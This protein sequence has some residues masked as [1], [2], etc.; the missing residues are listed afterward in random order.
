M[1][2]RTLGPARRIGTLEEVS[3]AVISI[4]GND[5]ISGASLAVD[6]GLSALELIARI[7]EFLRNAWNAYKIC[8][9]ANGNLCDIRNVGFV[10]SPN[11]ED[12][13]HDR[14]AHRLWSL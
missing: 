1:S 7:G 9:R 14:W 4:I 8:A 12:A 6:G 10:A 2:A 5:Y 13:S 3:Q 11:A